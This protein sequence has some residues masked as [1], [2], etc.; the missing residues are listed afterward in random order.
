MGWLDGRYGEIAPLFSPIKFLTDWE[1]A[2]ALRVPINVYKPRN[3]AAK[4][5]VNL[6]AE[7]LERIGVT[8]HA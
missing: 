1:K 5:A 4:E 7:L 3:A 6:A 8:T 2:E